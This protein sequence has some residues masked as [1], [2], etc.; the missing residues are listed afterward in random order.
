VTGWPHLVV[1]TTTKGPF[2]ASLGRTCRT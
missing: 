2:S 1:W